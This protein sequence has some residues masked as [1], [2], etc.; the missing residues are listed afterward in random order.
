MCVCVCVSLA[1]N[2]S[3]IAFSRRCDLFLRCS[4]SNALYLVYPSTIINKFSM[5]NKGIMRDVLTLL[6]VYGEIL[7]FI[8]CII[9][10]QLICHTECYN[11]N[12]EKLWRGFYAKLGGM[13]MSPGCTVLVQFH[14]ASNQTTGVSLSKHL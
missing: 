4:V 10:S 14:P 6:S 12:S 11:K 7:P 9:R 8:S 2:G 1:I 3:I 13:T 5:K